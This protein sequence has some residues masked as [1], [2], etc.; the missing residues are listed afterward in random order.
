MEGTVTISVSDFEMLRKYEKA[1]NEAYKALQ[2]CDFEDDEGKTVGIKPVL[3]ALK[4][5]SFI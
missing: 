1:A 4:V 3:E 2:K 5:L